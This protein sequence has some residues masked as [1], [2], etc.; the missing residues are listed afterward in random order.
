VG[1]GHNRPIRL[2]QVWARRRGASIQPEPGAVRV[3]REK[4]HVR[5][6]TGRAE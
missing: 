3:V 5:A 1:A 2:T 6:G 4:K